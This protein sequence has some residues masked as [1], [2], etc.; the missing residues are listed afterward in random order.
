MSLLYSLMQTL[1]CFI[2][3]KMAD[4]SKI[5]FASRQTEYT[6]VDNNVD[7]WTAIICRVRDK[8]RKWAESWLRTFFHKKN[9]LKDKLT[10]ISLNMLQWKEKALHGSICIIYVIL[11]TFHPIQLRGSLFL[12]SK[13]LKESS[14]TQKSKQRKFFDTLYRKRS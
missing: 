12:S 7:K 10:E 14:S 8:P 9:E 13:R 4:H 6:N 3:S 2:L 1:Q 5:L 11:Y